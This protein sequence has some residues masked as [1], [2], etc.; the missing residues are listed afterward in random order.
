MSQKQEL[1][2][3]LRQQDMTGRLWPWLA[4]LPRASVLVPLL[5]WNGEPH[6]LLT[7]RSEQLRTNKGEVCFPGGKQDPQDQDETA[8]ALRE[9]LEEIGLPPDQVEVVCQLVP[10]I[11]MRGLMVTPVVGFVPPDFE[12]KPNPDEVSAIFHM[13]LA[14]FLSP[15][16]H[17]DRKITAPGGS[18]FNIHYFTYQEAKSGEAEGPSYQIWGL[19]SIICIV[20]ATI[21]LGRAPEFPVNFDV[22][23]PQGFME[24]YLNDRRIPNKL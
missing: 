22:S 3:R 5:L 24:Q 15:I 19:T 23:N 11:N 7:V 2:S 10:I 4:K 14:H 6:V 9:A 20:V 13:P 21:V 1:V 16:N 8:T 17:R 18:T 12:P